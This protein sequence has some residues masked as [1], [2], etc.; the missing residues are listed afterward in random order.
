MVWGG[1]RGNVT[2]D[3]PLM[4]GWGGEEA[5]RNGGRKTAPLWSQLTVNGHVCLLILYSKL[6]DAGWKG[7]GGV[8]SCQNREEKF[9]EIPRKENEIKVKFGQELLRPRARARLQTPEPPRASM[10]GRTGKVESLSYRFSAS[11]SLVFASYTW[12]HPP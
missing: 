10:P 5:Q 8:M 11:D 12:G 4:R 9:K 6:G 7:G 1:G 2:A 3:L